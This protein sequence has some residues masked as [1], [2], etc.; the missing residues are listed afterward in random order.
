MEQLGEIEELGLKV[1]VDGRE[2]AAIL[3]SLQVRDRKAEDLDGR[4]NSLTILDGNE[5]HYE[6]PAPRLILVLPIDLDT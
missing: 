1:Q 3:E 5:L 2:H 4:N 6:Y